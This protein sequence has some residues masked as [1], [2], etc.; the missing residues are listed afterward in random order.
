MFC[1]RKIIFFFLFQTSVSKGTRP[2]KLP[3]FARRPASPSNSTNFNHSP[4]SSGGSN[5]IAGI[6]RHGGELH[7]R[8][9]TMLLSF[10]IWKSLEPDAQS[11]FLWSVG[12]E[13]NFGHLHKEAKASHLLQKSHRLTLLSEKLFYFIESTHGDSDVHLSI[14]ACISWS[15]HMWLELYLPTVKKIWWSNAGNVSKED[16]SQLHMCVCT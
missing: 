15:L 14:T 11:T 4:H 1:L 2:V 12:T 10:L 6:N 9:G 8:S 7:N 13:V 3:A 16:E 5:N